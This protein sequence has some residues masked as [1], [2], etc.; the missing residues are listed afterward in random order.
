MFAASYSRTMAGAQRI[1]AERGQAMLTAPR[2]PK[3][4]IAPV[5]AP[6]PSN[7]VPFRSP[8]D[9]LR[10]IIDLVARMHGATLVGVLSPTRITRYKLARGAAMSA[11][12]QYSADQGKALSYKQIGD[13]FGRDPTTVCHAIKRREGLR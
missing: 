4:E 3:A 6:E 2:A 12:R 13:I 9:D 8:R 5:A 10:H 7:V 11:I 1:A